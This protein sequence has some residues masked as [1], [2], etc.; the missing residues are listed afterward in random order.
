MRE[1]L[2]TINSLDKEMKH[3]DCSCS[4]EERMS[5]HLVDCN[6]SDIRAA[7]HDLMVTVKNHVSTGKCQRCGKITVAWRRKPN[8]WCS[9]SCRVTAFQKAQRQNKNKKGLNHDHTRRT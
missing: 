5:G 6:V 8:K 7:H 4:I 9:N 1:L 3:L 2:K